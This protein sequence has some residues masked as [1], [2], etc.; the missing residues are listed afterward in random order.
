MAHGRLLLVPAH[1]AGLRVDRFLA[2]H[3]QVPAGLLHKLLRKG[4]ISRVGADGRGQTIQGAD[5]VHEGMELRI[6]DAVQPSAKRARVPDAPAASTAAVA[7]PIPVLFENDALA[8]LH[9]PAGLACQ[10]GSKLDSSVDQLLGAAYGP[11]TYR[12]VH[13]LDRHATGALVVA[14]SRLAA[15]A[16][17]QA[18]REHRVAKSYVAALHGTPAPPRGAIDAA[19]LNTGSSVVA[20]TASGAKPAAT[21]YRVLRASPPASLVALRTLSGRKHQIRVHCAQVLGC[22]ILGDAK[23]GAGHTCPLTPAPPGLF[24]HLA[25]I[26]V[27]DVD[28]SGNTSGSSTVTVSAPFPPFWEPVLSELH[29]PFSARS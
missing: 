13:R 26:S 24:L 10:G 9:K 7:A 3:L 20:S 4:A 15:A 28:C 27:P 11:Q 19:L 1:A 16:L 17:A 25:R 5:R 22:P 12:L 14:K 29:M 18:F 8:V 21:Y 23:Y 2:A 6:S